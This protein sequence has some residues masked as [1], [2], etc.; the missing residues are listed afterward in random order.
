MPIP[1]HVS[2]AE[3][4]ASAAYRAIADADFGVPDCDQAVG[5]KHIA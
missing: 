4:H 1:E 3:E 2:D 5:D